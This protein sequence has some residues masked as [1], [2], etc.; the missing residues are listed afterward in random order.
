MA[1]LF[2]RKNGIWYIVY[3][4]SGR[5]VWMS[6]HTREKIEADRYYESIKP[7]LKDHKI[8]CL[9]D[10]KRAILEYARINFRKG[11]AD[12]YRTSLQH[13]IACE[14]NKPL[15]FITRLE[16][17]HF[18]EYLVCRVSKVSANVYLRTI[19]TVFNTASRLNLIEE[20]PFKDCRLL[21]VPMKQPAYLSK[22]DLSRL[23]N[24]LQDDCIRILVL[25]AILT[26][27]R[28]GELINLHWSD[29]DLEKRLVHIRNRDSFVVKG[30]HPRSVP[31]NQDLYRLILGISRKSDFVFVDK[32]GRNFNGSFVTKKFKQAV[33][34]A[35]LSDLIHFHSLR[36]TFASYLVQSQTPLAEIQKLLGHSSV[37]TTQ[38][39][40]HL[41]EDN[42]RNATESIRLFEFS[43]KGLLN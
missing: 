27:M 42:L 35:G 10:L 4:D 40:S 31:I 18:K 24:G 25:F 28:R 26:G 1:T 7:S 13:L 14:K 33:R 23:L 34:T 16:A 38:I 39:Y 22:Q 8:T 12:L 17:E 19:K 3:N 5:R 21:R 43:P 36:H 15:R 41:E 37:V 11:T 32:K 20:N 6:T 9:E 2:K 29:I 30:M